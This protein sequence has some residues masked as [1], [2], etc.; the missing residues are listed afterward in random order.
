VIL[1]TTI[2][3]GIEDDRMRM[4]VFVSMRLAPEYSRS[5]VARMIK[6][7]LVLVNGAA[8]RASSGVRA[9]DRVDVAAAP[10]GAMFDPSTYK[11]G[12]APEIPLIFADDE[13]IV[14]NKPAG[15][16]V[17]PAPGHP[18]GTLVDAL[19]ARF[20]ELA[21]M[22][23]PDGVLRP[24]IVHRLDKDTS[25]VMVVARTPFSR[26]ELSRQFK[27]R[28]V[29][30]TYLAIVK[31]QVARDR[32]TIERPVGRHPVERKRM[33]VRSNAPRD[34][35]SHLTMLARFDGVDKVDAGTSL[36]RVKPDTGR[37]HQIRVHL[38]SI[39][40]P[41]LGDPLY[42]GKAV[43]GGFFKRQALHALALSIT[44]P[45]S[46]E[47]REFVAPPADD[48]VEY[49]AGKSFAADED[50]VRLWIERE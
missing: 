38:A 17:H 48:F 19:L 18:A 36:V 35:V 5:Q 15:M 44:H 16:T 46:E 45:R 20:P 14:V 49:L 24:G 39:G 29:Q 30:K 31:G 25:G 11:E 37:M 34:A 23:E 21:A 2:I 40:H 6:A 50:E 47:R 22:A 28:T 10:A 41:C 3:A 7:G 27:D 32:V 4:D 12:D 9:G 42:G 26:M 13:I 1:P 33:S 43:D 8:A